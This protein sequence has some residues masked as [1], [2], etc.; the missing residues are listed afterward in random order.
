M[1]TMAGASRGGSEPADVERRWGGWLTAGLV[2]V[3]LTG[4]IAPR[5]F[6][7]SAIGLIAL[8]LV[9]ARARRLPLSISA[10]LRPVLAALVG[11]FGL[12]VLSTVWSEARAET[13]LKSLTVGTAVLATVAVAGYMAAETSSAIARQL[14]RGLL[15][16]F[17]AGS[18]FLG[19]DTAAD[20]GLQML[21]INTLH[22]PQGLFKGYYVWQD[23]KI[24]LI[25][26]V[27]INR[28]LCALVILIWPAALAA[29]SVLAGKAV[30][31]AHAALLLAVVVAVFGSGSETA[32]LALVA[33]TVVMAL[34][35]LSFRWASY[36]VMAGWGVA[37][38][39][40]VPLVIVAHDY[41]QRQTQWLD[42]GVLS[43]ASPRVRINIAYE[44]AT[45]IKDA[46]VLGRGANASYVV[47]P[48]IDASRDPATALKD[49]GLGQHPHN[50][51]L[52]IWFE[53]GAVG[54]IA[55][56][57][58]GLVMIR[59]MAALREAA[60]PYALATFAAVASILA[61]AYGFWQP[62]LDGLIALSGLCM[63]IAITAWRLRPQLDSLGKAPKQ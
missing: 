45:R 38:L 37:C 13:A 56:L 60:R 9:A 41:G 40:V 7:F 48:Q 55:F 61:P 18:I 24:V 26:N 3:L 5:S 2:G 27:W 46:P 51:F 35:W 59:S 49:H 43:G 16:A 8:F 15:I 31:V 42:K 11:F 25:R 57:V 36:A 29:R 53:L 21:L 32:K 47:G 52:Q 10:D 14:A 33:G 30:L 17:L 50:A 28:S 19:V 39:L 34:A 44:Y 1:S 4:V 54:A 23:G 6:T 22:L 63:A 12:A 62:W 20:G 58:L